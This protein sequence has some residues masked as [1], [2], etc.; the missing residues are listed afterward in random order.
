MIKNDTVFGKYKE[1]FPICADL[2]VLFALPIPNAHGIHHTQP[3]RT[4]VTARNMLWRVS[5]EPKTSSQT[6]KVIVASRDS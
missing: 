4:S 5:K 2:C 6:T 3:P 1:K